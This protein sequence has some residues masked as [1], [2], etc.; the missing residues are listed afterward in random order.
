MLLEIK[1]GKLVAVLPGWHRKPNDTYV[2]CHMKHNNDPVINDLMA[3]IRETLRDEESD[4]W[5]TW[6]TH[7]GVNPET[8]KAAL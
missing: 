8:V 6:L 1:T 5:T 3:I 4:R 7:F 2:C